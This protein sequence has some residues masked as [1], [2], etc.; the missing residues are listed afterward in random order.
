MA[1]TP[2]TEEGLDAPGSAELRLLAHVLHAL[3]EQLGLRLDTFSLG[4]VASLIG[5]ASLAQDARLDCCGTTH[6]TGA[7]KCLGLLSLALYIY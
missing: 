6:L 3:G 4:P 5:K 2:H 1:H 7:G